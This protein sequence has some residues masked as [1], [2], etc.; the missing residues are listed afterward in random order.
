MRIPAITW[1]TDAAGAAPGGKSAR[2][3]PG[4]QTRFH[5]DPC[6][7][8]T[9]MTE[10][11]ALIFDVD[12][13]LAET[14]RDGHRV[15]FNRAFAELGLDWDWDVALYG[16]LLK[17]TGGKERI[18]TYLRRYRPEFVVKGDRVDFIADVHRAKTRHYVG[19]IGRGDLPLRPG[20]RR[21]LDEARAAGLTLGIATTTTPENVTALLSSTLGAE[22]LGWFAV[23][24]A[25][26][27]VPKKKPAPDIYHYA[28]AQL[29][30][31]AAACMAF[32][33]SANGVASARGAGLPV[34]VTEGL[35]SADEDLSAGNLVLDSLGEPGAPYR[36]LHGEAEPDGLRTNAW[37]NVDRLREWHRRWA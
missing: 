17:V 37:V 32:E 27:I 35:Y 23:I 31:P 13:T 29:G 6:Q 12:G 14:E 21:L 3:G 1:P 5:P 30:L 34:L 22:S 16:Q 8:R 10:L 11:R 24:A 2:C 18:D 33:D 19:L 36:V 9:P 26:D 15:A 25:G 20:V 28:L 4:R 7:M